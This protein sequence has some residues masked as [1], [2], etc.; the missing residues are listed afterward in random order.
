MSEGAGAEAIFSQT[1]G[2][3][4]GGGAAAAASP[5][6]DR[7]ST[8]ADPLAA[9]EA[10]DELLAVND[11][12]PEHH[13]KRK[14]TEP[15]FEVER[16][17]RI[18]GRE[19]Y[20]LRF[21]L[22]AV[23]FSRAVCEDNNSVG[24]TGARRVLGVDQKRIIS[25]V[26]DEDKI[27]ALVK[28]QPKRA[29]A[30]SLN[31]GLQAS[32]TDAEQALVGYI[33]EQREKHRGCGKTEVMKKVLEL[34]PDALGD[35]SATTTPDEV[36]NFQDRFNSWYQ[37][38]RKWRG[39]SIRRRT[40]VGQKLPNGHEGIAW[41][42]LMK[43]RKALVKRA[44][45]IYAGRHP[46]ALGESLID[47][48]DPCPA[49]LESVTAEVLDELG[50]MDQTPI[51]HEMPVETTLEKRGAKDARISTGAEMNCHCSCCCC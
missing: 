8:P 25:W 51:Q 45:E 20:T 35:L 9:G 34:K 32:I 50:N 21:K 4:G 3:C 47:A 1:S 41:A 31:A 6:A 39:F 10:I 22:R 44:G 36:L 12:H 24:K 46:C 48:E 33:S 13:A 28:L 2:D 42:T 18:G 27:K 37:R 14:Y 30:K 23:E 11:A 7:G 19:G 16:F 43:L 49:Q 29:G 38:F 17:G 15:G 26:Q 5:S 40:S